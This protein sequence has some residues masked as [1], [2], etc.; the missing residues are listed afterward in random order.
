MWMS[1]AGSGLF[2]LYEAARFIVFYLSVTDLMDRALNHGSAWRIGISV[3]YTLLYCIGAWIL[4]G[5]AM[6]RIETDDPPDIT[7][8]QVQCGKRLAIVTVLL[9]AALGF[10]LTSLRRV[11]IPEGGLDG[12]M[13]GR[14]LNALHSLIVSFPYVLL[15]I[16][17]TRIVD[18]DRNTVT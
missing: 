8:G 12:T 1:L 17:L 18:Q 15:L 13:A 6:G 9:S 5:M 11:V 3:L 2:A 4:T 10:A 14:E 7:P 16:A